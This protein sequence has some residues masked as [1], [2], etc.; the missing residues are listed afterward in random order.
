MKTLALLFIA[1]SAY[2]QSFDAP[3]SPLAT[4][5]GAVQ[6]QPTPVIRLAPDT[7][8]VADE[9]A[10]AY[11]VAMVSV[12]DSAKSIAGSAD[13]IVGAGDKIV[14]AAEKMADAAQRTSAP[15]VNLQ[16]YAPPQP[17][18]PTHPIR[19]TYDID[20]ARRESLRINKPVFLFVRKSADAASDAMEDMI[21]DSRSAISGFLC[22]QLDGDELDASD[23]NWLSVTAAPI[24]RVFNPGMTTYR[25]IAPGDAIASGPG[26]FAAGVA[27]CKEW[28]GNQPTALAPLQA[29]YRDDGWRS[30]SMVD[31]LPW[32]YYYATRGM[33][34]D[35]VSDRAMQI[36]YQRTYGSNCN[37]VSCSA[38]GGC[39]SG[40]CGMGGCGGVRIAA[41]RYYY[42][43]SNFNGGLFNAGSSCSSCGPGGCSTCGR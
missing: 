28:A 27:Q 35:P 15:N 31:S 12:S 20:T 8:S 14:A 30:A 16:Q 4:T 37:C 13:K 21:E 36:D 32:Q 23:R 41:P 29:R 5:P 26:A 18:R 6:Q 17:P 3:S 7:V 39:T 2:G 10:R 43:T 22:L 42:G 11:M 19:W 34:Y 38:G 24:C 9:Q 1:V 33:S 25:P 40:E